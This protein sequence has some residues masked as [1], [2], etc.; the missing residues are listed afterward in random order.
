LSDCQR[1]GSRVR[2]VSREALGERAVRDRVTINGIESVW[3]VR[4]RG[5]HGIYHHVS[6]KHLGRY[7]DEFAFRLRA[8]PRT[9]KTLAV[10]A[11][12]S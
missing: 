7:G 4:K 1:S 6:D 8:Y 5:I 9:G 10:Q 11:E 2:S 12:F 3:A